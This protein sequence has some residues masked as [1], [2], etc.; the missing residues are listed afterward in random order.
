MI[1]IKLLD[2]KGRPGRRIGERGR[3]VAG[4]HG[5]CGHRLGTEAA[6]PLADEGWRVVPVD[7]GH[8]ALGD[9]LTAKAPLRQGDR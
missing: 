9:P 2:G 3:L 4:K 5:E 8:P 6:Q 1:D 7:E